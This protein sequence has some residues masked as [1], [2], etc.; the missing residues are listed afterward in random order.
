MHDNNDNAHGA[1]NARV[2]TLGDQRSD[3]KTTFQPFVIED[4]NE[5]NQAT[6]K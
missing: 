3:V 4:H 1:K 5:S 2:N 6:Q